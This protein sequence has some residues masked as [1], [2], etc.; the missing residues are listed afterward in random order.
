MLKVCLHTT[1]ESETQTG[2]KDNKN[3]C[4]FK[5]SKKRILADC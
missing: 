5:K 3:K 4:N 1:I 2:G